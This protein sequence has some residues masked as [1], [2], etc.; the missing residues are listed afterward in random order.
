MKRFSASDIALN[1]IR[2]GLIAAIIVTVILRLA[3]NG[4]VSTI[5]INDVSSA[6]LSADSVVSAASSDKSSSLSEDGPVLVNINTAAVTELTQLDGIGESKA[7][8]IVEYRE[9]HGGFATVDELLN[10]PGIGEKTLANIRR[11]ITI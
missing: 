7:A 8:A 4:A 1:V 10:V 11:Q 6:P 5:S 3:S 2:F 9:K